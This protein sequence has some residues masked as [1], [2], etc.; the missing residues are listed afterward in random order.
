M[1][2]NMIVVVV[3]AVL[4]IISLAQAVQLNSLKDSIESGT[5][6]TAS[7]EQVGKENTGSTAS[8]PAALPK[9]LDN[10]PQMVGGC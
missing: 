9:S 6:K 10:L 5:I 1:K 8:A 2:Q 3:L 4:V 7:T